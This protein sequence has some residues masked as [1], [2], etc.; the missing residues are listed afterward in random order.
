MRDRPARALAAL[1]AALFLYIVVAPALPAS[2]AGYPR[3]V[4]IAPFVSLAKEDIGATVAVL[5][6]LLA[7]RLMALAGA[8]VMLLPAGGKS[9]DAAAKEA[10]YPLL[11]QG[12]VSKL[13]K[14]YSIDTTV[15][16]LST[17]GSAGAFFATAAT[18]DD[19]IAQL[20]TLSGEI[21]EKVFGVQGAVRAVSPVP[22]AAPPPAPSPAAVAVV[23]GIPVAA[24][25]SAAAAGGPPPAGPAPLAA[26]WF[27]EGRIPTAIERI[28]QS[29]KV[30]DELYRV[31][32]ADVDGDGEP[33]IVATGK[34]TVWFFKV[35]G[36]EIVPFPPLRIARRLGSQLLNVEIFDAD[37]DGKPEIFVTELADDRLSSFALQYRNGRFDVVSSDLP[38][39]IVLLSNLDGKPALAGQRTG[40]NE[41][42]TKGVNLLEY[43][44]GAVSDGKDLKL[45]MDDG[46]F[47]LNAVPVG[48]DGKFLYVDADEHLRLLDGSGKS[49][50]ATKEYFARGWIYI[51]RGMPRL[52][53]VSPPHTYVRGRVVPVGGEPGAPWLLTRTAEG[54]EIM[55]DTRSFKSSRIVVGRYEGTSFNVR[56]GSEA[57]SGFISDAAPTLRAGDAGPLVAATILESTEGVS[58]EAA[59]RIV[60]Y[61]FR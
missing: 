24:A 13:G 6:R 34:R 39:Y 50:S 54:A 11:L 58:S 2:A 16:D 17:G 14:G 38:Y 59:S 51:S 10:K 27:S 40:F 29:D 56:L 28:A 45:R 15:T 21:A 22:A 41:L 4:A 8:E 61:Q 18:E 30:P 9:P 31:A 26:A 55:K 19:I 44:N 5:P 1:G 37:G 7:S 57:S 25:A 12:T 23:G 52:Y 20:G 33:E 53:D 3:R 36:K 60:L 48:K 35:K 43:R 32:I 42:F 49:L 47:G 46:I